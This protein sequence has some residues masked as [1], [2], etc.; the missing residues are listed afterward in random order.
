MSFVCK[1]INNIDVRGTITIF[2]KMAPKSNIA[3]TNL[4]CLRLIISIIQISYYSIILFTKNTSII[5]VG[6][7]VNPLI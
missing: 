3:S 4:E 2:I 7:L 6:S 1:P 5:K